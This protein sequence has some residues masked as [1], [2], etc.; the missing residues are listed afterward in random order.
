M[1]R[2]FYILALILVP[3]FAFVSCASVPKSAFPPDGVY[4][5]DFERYVD[6][7]EVTAV[8][9]SYGMDAYQTVLKKYSGMLSSCRAEL[10]S[11]R[12]RGF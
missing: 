5:Y 1:K 4:S 6:C 12:R 2:F 8:Y 11:S 3:A 9:K 7:V 10:S